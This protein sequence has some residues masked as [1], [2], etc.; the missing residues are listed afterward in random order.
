MQNKCEARDG[1][2]TDF[3]G[4]TTYDETTLLDAVQRFDVGRENLAQ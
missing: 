4:G 3:Y 1:A 2:R